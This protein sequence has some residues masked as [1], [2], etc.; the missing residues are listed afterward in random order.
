MQTTKFEPKEKLGQFVREFAKRLGKAG[1]V[2]KVYE[3]DG[4]VKFEEIR[5]KEPHLYTANVD[6]AHYGG[7]WRL[8]EDDKT[9]YNVYDPRVTQKLH[10][11]HELNY[12]D[13]VVFD[14]LVNKVADDLKV[15]FNLKSKWGSIRAGTQWGEW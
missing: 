10:M 8:G 7:N 13:W 3:K 11:R 6:G 2:G 12:E 1:M 15:E 5:M 9:A 14:E 4:N